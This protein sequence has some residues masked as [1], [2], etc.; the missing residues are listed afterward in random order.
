MITAAHPLAAHLLASTCQLS[1]PDPFSNFFG[2]LGWQ[3]LSA[4][5]VKPCDMTGDYVAHWL[6]SGMTV[7]NA[8]P[9]SSCAALVESWSTVNGECLTYQIWN[10]MQ[11]AGYPLVA[12]AVGARFTRMVGQSGYSTSLGWSLADPL[13]RAVVA[14]GMIRVSFM[15]LV[16]THLA[17]TLLGGHLYTGIIG[18]GGASLGI[19]T[20]LTTDLLVT[21]IQWLYSAFALVLIMAS[22]I[23]FEVCVILSPL[24]IP[25][26]VYGRD[27]SV[28]S[29]YYKTVLGALALP[30]AVG[31]GWG[32]VVRLTH[33]LDQNTGDVLPH[34]CSA[35]NAA[36]CSNQPGWAMIAQLIVLLAGIVF[37]GK[38]IRATTGELFSGHGLL[39]NLFLLESTMLGSGR[40]LGRAG[41][42]VPQRMALASHRNLSRFGASGWMPHRVAQWVQDKTTHQVAAVQTARSMME[43]SKAVREVVAGLM[44]PVEFRDR[45]ISLEEQ[46][47]AMIAHG[48]MEDASE[49]TSRFTD[50]RKQGLIPVVF[51]GLPA[52]R[53]MEIAAQA[54]AHEG[55]YGV[56]SGR[57]QG[58]PLRNAGRWRLYDVMRDPMVENIRLLGESLGRQRGVANLARPGQPGGYVGRQVRPGY[59]R[60]PH[61]IPPPGVR[62]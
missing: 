4:I 44:T 36:T 24:V 3:L 55:R 30:V 15:A 9:T 35:N 12:V 27:A 46:A 21:A 62:P 13:L 53:K 14:I 1:T 37:M 40:I 10:T 16:Q 38:F 33:Q 11:Y 23:A 29:W 48:N 2:W 34:I 28:F 52:A 42:F 61:I 32:V 39:T 8:N 43:G 31:V 5:R 17:T 7:S 25:I 54:I 26:W 20:G 58:D 57:G 41:A 60:P 18:V 59:P 22:T 49:L 50:E 6:T 19:T 47:R 45:F 51:D 56:G